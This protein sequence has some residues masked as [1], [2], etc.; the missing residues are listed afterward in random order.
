LP[1]EFNRLRKERVRIG[2]VDLKIASIVLVN[3]AT[4]VSS[5]LRDFSKVP[6]LRVE[7]SHYQPH[8]RPPAG[9]TFYETTNRKAK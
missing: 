6:G 7:D 9:H 1:D 8:S 3:D 2:T 5:N 4:L